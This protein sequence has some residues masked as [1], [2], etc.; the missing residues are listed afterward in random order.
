[1]TKYVFIFFLPGSAGN[2]FSRCI[3]LISDRSYCW[4]DKN[5]P[6]LELTLNDKFN[7]CQY[8]ESTQFSNWRDFERH[9]VHYSSKFE[10]WALPDQSI[11]I[12]HNHPNYNMF[13]KN[14][15]GPGDQQYAFYIDPTENFEW[16]L[17]N[18]LYKHSYIDVSWFTTGKEMLTDNSI[19]KIKLSDIIGSATGCLNA[20]QQVCSSIG[21][22]LNDENKQTIEKLWHQWINTTL[23]KTKFDEFKKEIGYFN[24]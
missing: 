8:I 19:I 23:P 10:H 22:S 9:I 24:S 4:V 1:M 16:V 18:A 20:V 17:L 15:M 12:W 5:N 13:N 3:S 6:C 11:S 14:L 21:V 7:L 2:F